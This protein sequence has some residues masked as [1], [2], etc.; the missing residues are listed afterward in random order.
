MRN[1][2]KF[3]TLSVPAIVLFAAASSCFAQAQVTES[4]SETPTAV[5][6]AGSELSLSLNRTQPVNIERTFSEV[7]SSSVPKATSSKALTS[8]AFSAT[9]RFTSM[10]TNRFYGDEL[11][12]SASLPSSL[13]NKTGKSTVEFVPSRGQKL[14][15]DE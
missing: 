12:A 6:V 3:S 7:N 5:T 4:R 14:P 15:D 9:S 1:S 8:A 11:K 2:V 13:D 10:D